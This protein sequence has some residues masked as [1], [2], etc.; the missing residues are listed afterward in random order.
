MKNPTLKM[1]SAAFLK[2]N[3]VH[4]ASALLAYIKLGSIAKLQYRFD[5]F[6]AFLVLPILGFLVESAFWI[7][8]FHTSERETLGGFT[9]PQYITYLLWLMTQ[10]GGA[11]WRFERNMIN[12]INSGAVNALLVRPSSFYEFYLGQLLGFKLMM[13]VTSI[14][15]ILLVAYWWQLPLITSHLLP[16]VC[17]GLFYLIMMHT[18]NFAIACLAFSFDNVYSLNITKNMIVWFM[19][20]EL[21]PLDLLPAP[22]GE[23]LILLPFSC[24]VYIPASYISGRVSTEVFLNGFV[25][26]AMGCVVFGLLARLM[27]KR[28]LRRYSG[29]GA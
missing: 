21:F 8:L 23:W 18:F 15:L 20:G 4:S 13:L 19:A 25:S 14:P 22:L 26:V 7:G 12:D 2:K 28:G 3:L 24:G 11:N 5:F 9:K 6:I 1:L 17:L 27:W 10:L 16:A 29:T